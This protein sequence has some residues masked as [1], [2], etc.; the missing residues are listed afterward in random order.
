M[1]LEYIDGGD[2]MSMREDT[3]DPSASPIFFSKK[4]GGPFN[5]EDASKLFR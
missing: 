5:E 4:T 3:E 1:V 2:L